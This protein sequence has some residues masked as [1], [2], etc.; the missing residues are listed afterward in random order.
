[1]MPRQLSR[2][3]R[4]SQRNR[5]RRES[6]AVDGAFQVSGR[7]EL[8][9]RSFDGNLPGGRRADPYCVSGVADGGARLILDL[10]AVCEPPK[11]D[12]GVQEKVQSFL[13]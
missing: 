3:I 13:P 9:E 8:A 5:Q 6:A 11:Q 2:G 4:V 12:V 7:P 10:N 1:M